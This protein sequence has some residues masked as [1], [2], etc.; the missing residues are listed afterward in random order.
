MPSYI[1][2][3]L[4]EQ[5]KDYYDLNCYAYFNCRSKGKINRDEF[6]NITIQLSDN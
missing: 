1:Y 6:P 2:N 4:K 5:L 3:V